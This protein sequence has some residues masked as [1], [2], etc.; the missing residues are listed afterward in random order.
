MEHAENLC[1]AYLW[2]A[3]RVRVALQ[4][5]VG[6]TGCYRQLHNDVLDFLNAA[7]NVGSTSWFHSDIIKNWLMVE[8]G[9][10]SCRRLPIAAGVCLNYARM[11]SYCWGPSCGP[12]SSRSASQSESER[13]GWP[14]MCRNQQ[15]LPQKHVAN[16]GAIQNIK[17]VEVS[18]QDGQKAS[19]WIWPPR[20]SATGV[21]DS[22][23]QWQNHVSAW[24]SL[25]TP[26]R[27]AVADDPDA[28]D[29]LVRSVLQTFPKIGRQK[30][31]LRLREGLIGCWPQI[32]SGI[33]MAITV[34][35]FDIKV[36]FLFTNV[37]WDRID[38]MG[39]N[40]SCIHRWEDRPY[41]TD[42]VQQQ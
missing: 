23:K 7:R 9:S 40:M 6:D 28:L 21:S 39:Y 4:I 14:P 27:S 26:A 34:S 10:D 38:L 2:L 20:K 30:L 24:L 5:H 32:V 37:D 16:G 12:P 29:E 25:S 18:W 33:T 35:F 8:H 36:T 42:S 11:P 22:S 31:D 13:K 1:Q 3:E 19:T 17:V 41:Y 15:K